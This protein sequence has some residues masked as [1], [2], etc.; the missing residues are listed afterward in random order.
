MK[1]GHTLADRQLLLRVVNTR[2]VAI[3]RELPIS[4]PYMPLP[5]FCHMAF[6]VGEQRDTALGTDRHSEPCHLQLGGT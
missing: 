5:Q 1:L 6:L 3:G 2:Q 4:N